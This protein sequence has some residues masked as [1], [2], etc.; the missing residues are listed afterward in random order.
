[1]KKYPVIYKG[2]EYEVRW[3]ERI[4]DYRCR[5]KALVIY[6]VTASKILKRKKYKY[7]YMEYRSELFCYAHLQ[8]D[9]PDFYIKE[10][11]RLFE[12]YEEYEKEKREKEM[13]E[14][15]KKKALAEWDGVIDGE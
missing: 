6:E 12:F 13:I 15:N 1:M 3:E 4:V 9:D 8:K 14:S 10:V 5:P 7:V 11:K 2:K